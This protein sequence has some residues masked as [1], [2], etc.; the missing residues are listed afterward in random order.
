M[1]I[2]FYTIALAF[3]V[4]FTSCDDAD[5]NTTNPTPPS[6]FTGYEFTITGDS[7]FTV[8]GGSTFIPSGDTS[9]FMGF[10][11]PSSDFN[12]SISALSS[13]IFTAQTLP[14]TD[15][16]TTNVTRPIFVFSATTGGFSTV[17]LPNGGSMEITNATSTKLEGTITNLK[18]IK[19]SSGARKNLVLN[20]RFSSIG[21]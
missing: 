21:F 1:K 15:T 14:S 12:A 2:K 9:V 17:Y 11:S 7:T 6:T 20:G 4:V 3:F 5:D 19:V 10:V 13:D 16:N 18:L 8:K